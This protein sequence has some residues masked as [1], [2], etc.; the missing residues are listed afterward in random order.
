LEAERDDELYR[1]RAENRDLKERVRALEEQLVYLRTHGTL[2]RGLSGEQLVSS[3]IGGTLTVHTA[4]FDVATR[5][6]KSI[7]VKSGKLTNAGAGDQSS[8]RRWTWQKVF[9][10]TNQKQYDYLLLVGEANSVHRHCY[11]DPSSP[12]VLFC[13]P[14]DRV[15]E[16]TTAGTRGALGI[17]LN[18]NPLKARGRAKLLFDEFQVT[19]H[20][21]KSQFGALAQDEFES[22]FEASERIAS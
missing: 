2:A 17:Q 3:S 14:Y 7:E 6:G 4:S 5:D 18:S 9:G 12:F 19:L 13:I 21:F 15:S 22:T 11:R 20:E 16:F 1:L 8:F 10:E